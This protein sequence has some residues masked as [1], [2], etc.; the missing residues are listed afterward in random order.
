M[1]LYN[2]GSN[3]VR[4]FFFF[5]KGFFSQELLKGLCILTLFLTDL[6]FSSSVLL[7]LFLLF[8][9]KNFCFMIFFL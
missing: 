3:P 1:V 6:F 2:V 8:S 5:Y 7:L 9:F 4:R